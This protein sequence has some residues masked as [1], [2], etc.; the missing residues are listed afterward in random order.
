[1]I[2]RNGGSAIQWE[3]MKRYTSWALA[4]VALA[5]AA[6]LN[7]RVTKLETRLKQVQ[8]EQRNTAWELQSLRKPKFQPL[9]LNR[10][11]ERDAIR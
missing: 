10:P 4:G 9:V 5:Y 7:I 8:E 2:E 11:I 1:V 6:Y 3:R